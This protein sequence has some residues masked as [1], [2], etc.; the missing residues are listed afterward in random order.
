[1]KTTF[2]ENLDHFHLKI[3]KNL[4][5]FHKSSILQSKNQN[6]ENRHIYPA[7]I[8]NVKFFYFFEKFRSNMS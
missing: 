4:K 7:N 8:E 5:K 1:M 2:L 3:K 6:F